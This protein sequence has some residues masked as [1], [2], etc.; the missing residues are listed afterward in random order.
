MRRAIFYLAANLIMTFIELPYE[1]TN[2]FEL[3]LGYFITSSVL[4]LINYIF[5]RIAYNFVGWCA[6][7]T[8]ADSAE[9]SRLHWLIRFLLTL[10]LY[11]L[12]YLPF[13]SKCLTH[14]IHWFYLLIVKR[15]NE[16]LLEF[17]HVLIN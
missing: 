2:G 12:T 11:A 13:V 5:Y 17:T 7:L 4:A 8:D 1:Y 16:F 9:M 6:A 10:I 3:L 14:M 15:Y